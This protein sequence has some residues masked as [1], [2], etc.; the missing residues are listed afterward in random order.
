MHS[1]LHIASLYSKKVVGGL[2]LVPVR[3]LCRNT[4]VDLAVLHSFRHGGEQ[5][6]MVPMLVVLLGHF[7]DLQILE[8][9]RRPVEHVEILAHVVWGN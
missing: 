4:A 1:S 9:T 6:L 5:M 2:D 7:V 3:R 8:E